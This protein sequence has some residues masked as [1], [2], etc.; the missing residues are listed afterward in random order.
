MAKKQKL[1]TEAE[2]FYVS[3]HVNEK[4]AEE[5]AEVIG[6]TVQ[7]VTEYIEHLGQQ[8]ANKLIPSMAKAQN[9]KPGTYMMTEQMAMAGDDARAGRQQITDAQIDEAVALKN[10]ALAAQ[11][12]AEKTK[13]QNPGNPVSPKDDHIMV[14]DPSRPTR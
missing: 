8:R 12:Q 13:Q 1:L 14:L 9:F 2:R 6:V 3:Q 7:Q 11:L 5:I 4:T 10:Y